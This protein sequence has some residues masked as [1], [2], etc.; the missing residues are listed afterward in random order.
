MRQQ[1]CRIDEKNRAHEHMQDMKAGRCPTV[2]PHPQRYHSRSPSEDS[3]SPRTENAFLPPRGCFALTAS[4]SVS[5]R[6]AYRGQFCETADR[7]K[8]LS[9]V[10]TV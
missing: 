6:C 3:I 4:V 1:S 2:F 10:T 7:C 5:A 9:C 8:H